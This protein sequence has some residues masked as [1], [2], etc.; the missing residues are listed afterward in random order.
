MGGATSTPEG[1]WLRYER[2]TQALLIVNTIFFPHKQEHKIRL[3]SI[4]FLHLVPC[5]PL[6]YDCM[7][8]CVLKES[9]TARHL[10]PQTLPNGNCKYGRSPNP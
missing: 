6:Y 7:Q 9:K 3:E 10:A 1:T 4:P 2:G 8:N 5:P